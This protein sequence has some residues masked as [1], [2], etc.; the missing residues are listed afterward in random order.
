VSE[1]LGIPQIE[2][3]AVEMPGAYGDW[4]F[5][6][7]APWAPLWVRVKT[8]TMTAKGPIFCQ[9]FELRGV[10]TVSFACDREH[11]ELY[12]AMFPDVVVR[13]YH[14]PPVLQPFVN[15]M[16]LDGSVPDDVLLEM[17]DHAFEAVLAKLPKKH[18]REIEALVETA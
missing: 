13:G 2:E 3:M 10:P 16:S 11:G 14:C 8:P 6:D 15:T 7:T 12:R 9:L 4:P 5:G 1:Y 17:L 18:Q